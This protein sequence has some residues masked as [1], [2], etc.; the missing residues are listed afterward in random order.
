MKKRYALS[1]LLAFVLAVA[2]VVSCYGHR[3]RADAGPQIASQ[4]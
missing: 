1:G 4:Y 3:S 2:V